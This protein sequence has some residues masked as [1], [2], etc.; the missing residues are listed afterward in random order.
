MYEILN[1]FKPNWGSILILIQLKILSEF[2]SIVL[3]PLSD[4][5]KEKPVLFKA[6]CIKLIATIIIIWVT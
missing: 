1:Q 3:T 5:L 4:H 2:V 6:K